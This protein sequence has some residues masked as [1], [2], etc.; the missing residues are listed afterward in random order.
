MSTNRPWYKR[1]PSDFIQ[2]TVGLSLEEKGAYSLILDLIYDKG[3]PIVD[4]ARYLAG[5]CNVSLR[6]W[7]AIRERLIF[8]KKIT[9]LNGV[10]RCPVVKKWVKM[11]G[12]EA[13]ST[14]IR[15]FVFKRDG[16]VC[17]YCGDVEGPFQIDHKHPVFL[18]GTNDIDN[19][20]VACR[21]CNLSKGAKPLD[22]WRALQ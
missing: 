3:A 18:G 4:D 16:F 19:L 14:S 11:A 12:R 15:E 13:L 8:A 20:T 21:A 9:V 10:I 6:K 17:S 1:Y 5:I 2:G 7:A 22:E